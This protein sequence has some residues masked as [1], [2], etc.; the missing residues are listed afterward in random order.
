MIDP[1]NLIAICRTSY[2]TMAEYTLVG[3]YFSFL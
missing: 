1:L 3:F 2:P